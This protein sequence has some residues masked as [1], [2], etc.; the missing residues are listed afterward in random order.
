MRETKNLR[1]NLGPSLALLFPY[2][3]QELAPGRAAE[4]REVGLSGANKRLFW[5]GRFNSASLGLKT[6]GSSGNPST[7]LMP[8]VSC[9][10]GHA[11]S[12][13]L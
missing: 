8:A 7:L 6:Q 11:P 10:P 13:D 1:I 4:G 12:K 5:L 3:L 2:R 9:G